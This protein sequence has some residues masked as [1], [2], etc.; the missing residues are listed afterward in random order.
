MRHV[1]G[2]GSEWF[3]GPIERLD[4]HRYVHLIRDPN[5][6]ER[7]PRE[8]R[9]GQELK[10]NTKAG[11][12]Q[13]EA[14]KEAIL[15][16][17]ADGEPRTFNCM[18]VG[19]ADVT[20]DVVFERPPDQALW[21]LVASYQL[22]HTNEAP[23][24]FRRPPGFKQHAQSAPG[25]LM[26]VCGRSIFLANK[27][28]EQLCLDKSDVTCLACTQIMSD[29]N[30]VNLTQAKLEDDMGLLPRN[31]EAA[32]RVAAKADAKAAKKKEVIKDPVNPILAEGAWRQLANALVAARKRGEKIVQGHCTHC[33]SHTD[34]KTCCILC[35]FSYF[36]DEEM[37]EQKAAKILMVPERWLL[38]VIS[39][40]DKDGDEITYPSAKRLGSKLWRKYGPPKK[41]R[42]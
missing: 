23:I 7:S 1:Y 30:Y 31:I 20:A 3:T 40:F 5:D 24:L 16:H 27:L 25:H 36:K 12:G 6:P 14:W 21:E 42:A 4:M 8:N 26:S 38:D 29:P 9:R 11:Q 19:I 35:A 32:K 41:A 33:G 13:V 22:E 28:G 18:M 34:H 37:D 17:L 39:G 10:W 2:D 15:D